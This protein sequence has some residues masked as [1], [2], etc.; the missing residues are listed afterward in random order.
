MKRVVSPTTAAKSREGK[1]KTV[2]RIIVLFRWTSVSVRRR[3]GQG[4][5]T[6]GTNSQAMPCS[7][8]FSLVEDTEP[9]FSHAP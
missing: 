7:G 3:K 8:D 1:R 5:R 9:S 4:N 6:S 2:Y